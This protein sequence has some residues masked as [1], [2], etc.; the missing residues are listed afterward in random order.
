[1]IDPVILAAIL[2]LL[3]AAPSGT[4][5]ARLETFAAGITEAAGA[6]P[7]PFTGVAAHQA[8]GL[9][10][11]AIAWHESSFDERVIDCRRRG[12]AG[13][14]TAFQLLGPFA[15]GVKTPAADGRAAVYFSIAELCASV[16]LA[17][18]R[19]LAILEHHANTCKIGGPIAWYQGYASGS[20][21]KPAPIRIWSRGELRVIDA[22]AGATRCRTWERLATRAGLVGASCYRRAAIEHPPVDAE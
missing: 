13:D 22:D 9:A 6:S 11:V 21:G 15:R 10:L 12:A 1:M 20:C 18:G 3:P 19:A 17:A 2:S 8:A 7:G 5:R 4:E 16:P 14:A